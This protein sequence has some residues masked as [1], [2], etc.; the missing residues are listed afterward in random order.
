[1]K[2]ID[3]KTVMKAWLSKQIW[4]LAV[5]MTTCGAL[6]LMSCSNEDSPVSN[7][8]EPAYAGVPLIIFD[9][10]LGSSTDDLFALE[11]LY[12]YEEEGRCKLLGIVVDREGEDCAAVADVMN[13][14]FGRPDVPIALERNGIKNPHV[15]IDYQSL[16]TYTTDDGQPMFRRTISDYSSLP[17]G[18][19][20]YRRLLASQPDHSVTI[21]SVG[22]VTSLAALLTS[23]GDSISPLGGMEL[24]RRKVKR[25][26]VMGGVFGNS[27]EADYNFRQGL[28]F[29]RV[30]FSRW[31]KDVDV[32]FSPM[33]VGQDVE[34]APE[35]VIS[36]ISWT[37][38]HPVKQIYLRCNCYTGQK[39]WDPMVIVHAVE[40]DEVFS[41]SERG[42]VVL[43]SQGQTIFTPSAAGNSRY[44][45]PGSAAW[46]AAILE[47]IRRINMTHQ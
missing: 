10:D 14:Y 21:C 34:Y 43:T 44:Q 16:H 45:L 23:P 18:W 13:T 42:D 5:L 37:D 9:T 8:E 36:D 27:E 6:S 25:L 35:Q 15:W 2:S 32:V 46:G 26:Y 4:L 40:G 22:F 19:Q 20:L 1:M 47:E 31:P 30:F 11:M 17:D 7:E 28:S 38:A 24:V 33:E 12:R 39:M 3:R 41:L 29:A